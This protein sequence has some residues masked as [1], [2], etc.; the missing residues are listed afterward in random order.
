[1]RVLEAYPVQCL[2]ITGFRGFRCFCRFSALLPALA[3]GTG[4]YYR[5]AP[6]R[7]SSRG[8][9]AARRS[10]PLTIGTLNYMA[11]V[12]HS[13]Y[14]IVAPRILGKRKGKVLPL[15]FLKSTSMLRRNERK[16]HLRRYGRRE[17]RLPINAALRYPSNRLNKLPLAAYLPIL[18]Q[19]TRARSRILHH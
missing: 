19:Y 8:Q 17:C 12:G 4:T 9:V 3:T 14:S 6:P 15:P 2:A 7:I 1:M 13:T 10:A 16:K 11:P 18:R 5:M